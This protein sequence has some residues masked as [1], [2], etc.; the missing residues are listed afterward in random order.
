MLCVSS[1]GVREG[2]LLQEAFQLTVDV[3]GNCL[4]WSVEWEQYMVVMRGYRCCE[5]SVPCTYS[6]TL[7]YTFHVLIE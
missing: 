7:A 3:V 1:S 2:C 4:I 6:F 5:Y